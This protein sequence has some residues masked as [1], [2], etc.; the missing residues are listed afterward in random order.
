MVAAVKRFQQRRFVHT[1]DD[2]LSSPRYA[3]AAASFLMISTAR[4]ISASATPSS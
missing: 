2:L 1:Y 3:A 4:A